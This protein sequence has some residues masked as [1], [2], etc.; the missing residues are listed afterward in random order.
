MCFK[1]V[2][3]RSLLNFENLNKTAYA[4]RTTQVS[5][6]LE[7]TAEKC[8]QMPVNPYNTKKDFVYAY[9]CIRSLC[10]MQFIILRS[11]FMLLFFFWKVFTKGLDVT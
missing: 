10:F 4:I 1:Q 9:L 7:V 2:N 11:L 3:Q 8:I 5:E 6:C